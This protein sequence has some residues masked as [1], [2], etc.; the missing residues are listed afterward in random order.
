[1]WRTKY[2]FLSGTKTGTCSPWMPTAWWMSTWRWVRH[3]I[4][5][6]FPVLNNNQLKSTKPRGQR[7]FQCG[8]LWFC[9]GFFLSIKM[10]L[11]KSVTL[12]LYPVRLWLRS[13]CSTEDFYWGPPQDI[14][15]PTTTTSFFFF[16]LLLLAPSLFSPPL[17]SSPVWFHHHLRRCFPVGSSPGSAQQ[18]HRDPSGRL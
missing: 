1:M 16:F 3:L 7:L 11:V 18:H 4:S 10:W 5:I 6:N 12:C 2:S 17:L 15:K 13:L 14:Q 9:D 8:P